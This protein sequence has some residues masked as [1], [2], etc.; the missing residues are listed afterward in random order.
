[1]VLLTFGCVVY[2]QAAAC[3]RLP[4]S[5]A[6]TKLSSCFISIDLSPCHRFAIANHNILHLALADNKYILIQD[7][8]HLEVIEMSGTIYSGEPQAGFLLNG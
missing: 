6:V 1:M 7:V 5:Q 2:I 4:R 3:E 8:M